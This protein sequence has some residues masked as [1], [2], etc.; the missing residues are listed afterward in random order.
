MKA[1][2]E[3][4]ARQ[5]S[6]ASFKLMQHLRQIMWML[7]WK[8]CSFHESVKLK[9]VEGIVLVNNLHETAKVR[10]GY[11]DDTTGVRTAISYRVRTIYSM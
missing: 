6:A 9:K 10:T 5:P 2:F 4:Y 1:K 7:F 3:A 11:G 8:V